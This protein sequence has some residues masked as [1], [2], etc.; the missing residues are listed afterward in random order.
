[1]FK[2]CQRYRISLNPKK[3]IFSIEEGTLLGI[4]VSLDGIKIDPR[5]IEVIKSI[6][7]PHNKKEIQSFLG[8]R[9]SVMGFISYFIE[10]VK[11]L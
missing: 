8:K 3:G 11:P 9:N 5:R 6:T 10:I 7:P 4:V 1:M 2:R